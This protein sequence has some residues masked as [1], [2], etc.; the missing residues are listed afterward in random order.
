MKYSILMAVL[1]GTAAVRTAII[2]V[3]VPKFP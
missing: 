2:D 3:E 1:F